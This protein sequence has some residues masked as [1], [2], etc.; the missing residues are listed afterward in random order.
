MADPLNS[1]QFRK[2]SPKFEKF[3][4]SSID[5]P[6][7]RKHGGPRIGGTLLLAHGNLDRIRRTVGERDVSRIFPSRSA[8]PVPPWRQP[9]LPSPLLFAAISNPPSLSLL[10]LLLVSVAGSRSIHRLRY[11]DNELPGNRARNSNKPPDFSRTR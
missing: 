10:L 9:P 2:I 3:P 7:S 4:P 1:I 5:S 11:T 8:D 6:L